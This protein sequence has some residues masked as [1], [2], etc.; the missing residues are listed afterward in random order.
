MKEPVTVREETMRIPSYRVGEPDRNPLFLEKRVYQGSSGKVYPFPVIDRVSDDKTL[1][2]WRVIIMENEWL[3]IWIMPDLGG[4]I[5]RAMDKTNGYDFVYYN[6][7]IKPALVGLAG[8]W[9][10]GGI[11]FNW[12]QHH[13][14][15][16]FLPVEYTVIDGAGGSKTV[17]VGETDRMYGTR[18]SAR[19]TLNPDTAYLEIE[20]RLF[21][22]TDRSQTFLWWANP[23][24]AVNDSTR[25]IFPPDVNAVMDHGKRDVSEFPIAR[26]RYYKVDYSAGVDISRYRNIPVPTSYMVARTEFDFFG[27]YDEGRRA[28]LL[29]IADHR[30]SPGKKQWTWGCGEFGQAWDRNLSDEDGPYIELMAGVYTDNQPDFTWMQPGEAKDFVQLFLPYREIGTVKNATIHGAVS[31]ELADGILRAGVYVTARRSGLR[32][33]VRAG[34]CT[35]VDALFDLSPERSWTFQ[36]PVPPLAESEDLSI[37]VFDRE[38]M[39]L[40]SYV[41]SRRAPYPLPVPA[42]PIRSPEEL[43]T[44][45]DLYLAARHLEQY[46]H[47]TFEPE[48]YYEKALQ[49]DPGDM[50]SCTAYGTLLLA[51]GLAVRAEQLLRRAAERAMRHNP[52]PEHGDCLY[53]LGLALEVQDR[54]AEAEDAYGKAAWSAA[55]QGPASFALG[56]LA[57]RRGR[58]SEV[59]DRT[60]RAIVRNAWD[61]RSRHL[62]AAAYLRRGETDVAAREAAAALA[63][64]P[65]DFGALDLMRRLGTADAAQDLSRALRGSSYNA[66]QLALDYAAAGLFEEACGALDFAAASDGTILADP[67]VLLHRAVFAETLGRHEEAADLRRQACSLGPDRVF[68]NRLEDVSALER[69]IAANAADGKS[70]LYLGNL[71][72]DKK[73]YNEAI[74]RWETA[75]ARE[76]GLATAHRNLSIAYFNKRGNPE[77]ALSAMEQAFAL[78]SSDARVLLELDQLKKKMG[79]PVAERLAFLHEHEAL[80]VA[81]DDLSVERIALL[82]SLGDPG[83]A[84]RRLTERRFHPWEGGEGK[85]SRLWSLAKQ[86]AALRALTGGDPSAAI[87]LLNEARN[88]P[89]SF[90]EGKLYGTQENDILYRL[91]VARSLSGDERGAELA[92]S[93]AKDGISEPAGCMFYNDQPPETICYQGLALRRLGDEE[94]ARRRFECLVDYAL[95]H[96]DDTPRIDYFAVSLPDFLIFD[97][98]LTKKNAVHC[99]FIRALGLWGLGRPSEALGEFRKALATDPAHLA[100]AMHLRWAESGLL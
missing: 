52:N 77:A 55:W 36:T 40:V 81:R 78:D 67:L 14:P 12:P 96:A 49:R 31:L 60:G 72:Y 86:D 69:A 79:R 56:R 28:G 15:S 100:A 93:E 89:E 22:R 17:V 95:L 59:L 65:L 10:S 82:L 58:F 90:G 29:H 73:R 64:D 42:A 21:N 35:Y 6:R 25:S 27:G 45:E 41:T 1:E 98:D 71:L 94:G 30:V 8:P 57:A 50:R 68:P 4:R 20:G 24:F 74:S 53:Y 70:C 88:Y 34:V 39:L 5:Q 91:G 48:A 66:L 44:T 26:G 63:I 85:L 23:A 43:E 33:R 37:E 83:S 9:I 16:T 3:L 32:V 54:I 75:I 38:G 99:R 18:A 11:E 62:R 80:V 92:F 13:R 97:E 76:P 84:L 87:I 7:V 46:R 51:R 2:E 47:A 61:L 19:F